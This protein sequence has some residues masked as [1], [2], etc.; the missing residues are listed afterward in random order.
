MFQQIYQ[1]HF[2]SQEYRRAHPH[3]VEMS[4]DGGTNKRLKRDEQ[5]LQVDHGSS[6]GEESGRSGN[7]A[8]FDNGNTAMKPR[9]NRDE[10]EGRT[11]A[12]ATTAPDETNHES[13]EEEDVERLHMYV[14]IFNPG[15]Y[16]HFGCKSKAVFSFDIYIVCA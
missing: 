13:E 3:K 5:V 6:S 15:H 8:R 16:S 12:T 9:S 11:T 2:T 4:S 10:E 14:I 7:F 1:Q